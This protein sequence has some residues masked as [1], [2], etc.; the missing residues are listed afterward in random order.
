MRLTL[1]VRGQ[2]S[3]ALTSQRSS[4]GGFTIGIEDVRLAALED[5]DLARAKLVGGRQRK[6]R[7]GHR[8]GAMRAA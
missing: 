1:R 4:T 6:Q 8:V 3:P 7:I 5:L 2:M